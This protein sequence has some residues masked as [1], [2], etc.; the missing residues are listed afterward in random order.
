MTLPGPSETIETS[1][2]PFGIYKDLLGPV[3]TFWNL[4]E[5]PR[6]PES[7]P[8]ACANG[9]HLIGMADC[10]VRLNGQIVV[11]DSTVRLPWHLCQT[12]C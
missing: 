9:S 1:V 6:D 10:A 8:G 5:P 3:G 2:R 4:V 12:P 7:P 11:S